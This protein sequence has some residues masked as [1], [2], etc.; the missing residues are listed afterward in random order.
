MTDAV[1]TFS[2]LY[3]LL[4]PLDLLDLLDLR[5]YPRAVTALRELNF[6]SAKSGLSTLMNE[7]VHEHRPQIVHRHGGKEEMLL[8]RPDD[9]RRWLDTFRLTLR[10]TLDDGEVAVV[11]DPVGVLGVG[12]SLEA[13]LDD[14]VVELRAYTRRFF[15]RPHFYRETSAA[16]H[17]PWLLRFALTPAEEHR[18]LL[19]A[20]V[21]ASVPAGNKQLASPV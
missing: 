9:A 14:L 10:V 13:A 6:S 16:H 8:V 3:D 4:D 7:V 20:D 1:D 17:E 12:E 21:E 5:G 15:E 19:D 18:S 2:D 11:A